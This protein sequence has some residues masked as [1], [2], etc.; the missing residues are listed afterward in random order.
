MVY[1]PGIKHGNGKSPTW[2]FSSMI[3]P[4][5]HIGWGIS[6][7]QLLIKG[8]FPQILLLPLPS[9]GAAN[10]SVA[11]G[12][13]KPWTTCP[14]TLPLKVAS[15][16]KQDA[17][18]LLTICCWIIPIYSW[19]IPACYH[20]IYIS[21]TFYNIYIYITRVIQECINQ[22]LLFDTFCSSFLWVRMAAISIPG[23]SVSCSPGAHPVLSIVFTSSQDSLRTWGAWLMLSD[24]WD[25]S[26]KNDPS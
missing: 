15:I 1:T 10:V 25:S 26:I 7:C 12:H 5:K 11:P 8:P 6:H 24:N 4:W 2:T 3:F 19:I 13:Q 17:K 16:K 23:L 14:L 21:I 22:E 18:L 9:E 20:P